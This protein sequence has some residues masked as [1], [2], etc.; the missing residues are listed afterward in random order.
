LERWEDYLV[1]G[2]LDGLGMK[3]DK[4]VTPDMEKF[5]FP[6]TLHCRREH[7]LLQLQQHMGQY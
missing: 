7:L 3:T 2:V 1:L 6:S 4:R 5:K